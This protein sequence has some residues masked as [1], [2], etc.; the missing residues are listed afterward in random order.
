MSGRTI[1][2]K[3]HIQAL[4]DL[5]ATAQAEGV[6]PGKM[7]MRLTLGDAADLKRDPSVALH[8]ISFKDGE[9][10][11]LGVKVAEGG[12]TNSSLDR[13]PAAG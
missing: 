9:M 3:K 8:E 7:L 2:P 10:R 13:K 11:F 1:L 4:R 6:K 12:V 5:I